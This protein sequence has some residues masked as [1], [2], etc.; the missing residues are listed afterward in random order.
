VKVYPNVYYLCGG[1][2]N[3]MLPKADLSVSGTIK[4]VV[5]TCENKNCINFDNTCL[6]PPCEFTL[7]PKVTLQ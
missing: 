1:C 5:I 2:G 3:A 6:V 7:V 4:A